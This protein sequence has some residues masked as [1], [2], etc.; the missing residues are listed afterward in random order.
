[1]VCSDKTHY[2]QFKNAF[3]QTMRTNEVSNHY[4][5]EYSR[6]HAEIAPTTSSSSSGAARSFT[7][8]QPASTS[9]IAT[10]SGHPGTVMDDINDE[11]RLIVISDTFHEIRTVLL[12]Q[13]LPFCLYERLLILPLSDTTTIFF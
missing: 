13:I 7:T 8:P 11:A 1:M 3:I 12:L 10:A 9:H 4:N 6:I 2:N 5:N